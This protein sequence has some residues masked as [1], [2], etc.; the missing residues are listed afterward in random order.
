[1][2]RPAGGLSGT[3]ACLSVNYA[4][5]ELLLLPEEAAGGGWVACCVG[6]AIWKGNGHATS[7]GSGDVQEEVVLMV[8]EGHRI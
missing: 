6:K 8:V 4:I 1:M 5:V 3:G 7:R 2:S